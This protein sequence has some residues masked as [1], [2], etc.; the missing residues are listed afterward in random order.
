MRIK[1]DRGI[2]KKE[3]RCR[4]MNEIEILCSVESPAQKDSTIEINALCKEQDKLLYKFFVGKDGIWETLQDF[5]EG[6]KIEWIP[7]E[8]GKYII[9]VQAKTK[10][11][12]KP[13]DY[14]SRIDYIIGKDEEKLINKITIDKNVLK[15]GE[16]LKLKVECDK[17]HIVYK[18]WVREEDRWELVKDYSAENNLSFSVKNPGE[19]EILIECKELDSKNN[20][21]DFRKVQYKVLPLE[22]L[23]I[24]DFKC[25]S[26]ELLV[27]SEIDFQVETSHEDNRMVLYKFLKINSE[28]AVSSIQDYSTKRIVSF[29]ESIP[30]DYKMLC[31][32]KDM[33]SPKEYDDRALINYTVKLYNP[34]VIQSFTSDLSSPQISDTPIEL[35]AVAKGGKNLQYRFIIDGNISSD[36]GYIKEN[37]YL[38]Q[39]NRPG[40]YNLQ[41]YVRDASFEGKYEAKKEL[42]FVVDE[43][44]KIA[45]KFQEVILDKYK[46]YIKNE[47]INLKVIA[48]GGVEL[49]YSFVVLKDGKEVERVDYGTCDW[50]NFTPEN[51][52]LYQL[53]IRI[54]D[55]Y[56][57]KEY[58]CH[59]IVEF[60]VLDYLPA[61]IDYVLM[62]TKENYLVGDDISFEVVTKKTKQTKIKYILRINGHR[63]EDTG[64]VDA[65]KYSFT[66]KCSGKYTVELWVKSIFSTKEFD[67]KRELKIFVREAVQI[68]N[69]KIQCDKTEFKVNEAVVFSAKCEGGKDVCYEFYLAAQ[70]EWNL[71]EKYS[72]KNY[73]SFIPFD[74]GRYTVLVLCKSEYKNCGYEDYDRMEF[75]VE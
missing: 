7:K 37:T 31:F 58:D 36:S 54:K 55:K 46:E 64:Y 53:E 1:V 27:D 33:Y 21:D 5:K 57:R 67:N 8:E 22:K 9:M 65:K 56:S 41:L 4:R 60:Q 39:T 66:P 49:R 17:P 59:E 13:F 28:G 51:S 61:H 63:V 18:F 25:L 34:I 48:T 16:K 74:K 45:V 2:Y 44:S 19:Q 26:S 72:K 43:Q 69:A 62:Q 11:T 40:K 71:V 32:A 6:N 24:I 42:E 14:I 35:K 38:W 29:T 68:T 23:E 3:E 12:S 10:E 75:I 47:T 50:V 20:F 30:G 15:V 73:Y 52:G 70:G